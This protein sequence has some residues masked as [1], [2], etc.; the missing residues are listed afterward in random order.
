MISFKISGS[1]PSSWEDF[2]SLCDGVPHITLMTR[3]EFDDCDC[4]ADTATPAGWLDIVVDVPYI[5]NDTA[6]LAISDALGIANPD[7][8]A[9]IEAGFCRAV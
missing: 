9:I 1:L 3:V 4:D 2:F 8:I 5:D 6:R 7:D